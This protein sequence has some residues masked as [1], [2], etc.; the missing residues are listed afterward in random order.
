MNLFCSLY[1]AASNK[2]TLIKLSSHLKVIEEE[3]FWLKATDK[4]LV[5]KMGQLTRERNRLFNVSYLCPKESTN[6]IIQ[7]ELLRGRIEQLRGNR[8]TNWGKLICYEVE[9]KGLI[10]RI[11]R[12]KGIRPVTASNMPPA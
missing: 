3:I 5:D 12:L 9:R 11:N 10:R 8:T 7:I 4:L 6:S 2:V 1:L